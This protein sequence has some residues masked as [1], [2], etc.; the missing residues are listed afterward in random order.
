MFPGLAVSA[1]IVAERIARTATVLD[2]REA[3]ILRALV[4]DD[5]RALYA[6][7]NEYYRQALDSTIKKGYVS[8]Q[9]KG[10]VIT[11][12]GKRVVRDYLYQILDG[13]VNR[14]VAQTA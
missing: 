3:R 1:A 9:G 10:F 12:E 2:Q 13:Y 14:T 11:E 5:G 7:Q 6:Y 8:K 4:D